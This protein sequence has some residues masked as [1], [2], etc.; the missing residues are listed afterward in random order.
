MVVVMAVVLVLVRV[1]EK[2]LTRRWGFSPG[3]YQ[4]DVKPI[5]SVPPLSS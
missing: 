5:A 1:V 2:V 3:Q 4:C